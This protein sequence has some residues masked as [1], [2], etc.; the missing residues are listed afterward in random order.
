MQDTKEVI[1]PRLDTQT[2]S[3]EETKDNML[4]VYYLAPQYITDEITRMFLV[5][6]ELFELAI[7]HHD[8]VDKMK[9]SAFQML[10]NDGVISDEGYIVIR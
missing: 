9:P 5:D 2:S 6:L 3:A 10:F 7:I 4:Y 1:E 8:D